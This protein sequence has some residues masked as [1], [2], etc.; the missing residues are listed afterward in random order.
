MDKIEKYINSIYRDTN[1]K[2]KGAQ[3][4]KQEMT[5][6]LK[7]TVK[8]LQDNG[9]NE[10]E[11]IRIA[12]ERFGEEFQIRNELSQVMKFQKLF[13]KNVFISSLVVL[14]VSAILLTT[15]YF[16]QLEFNKRYNVMDAQIQ[17]AENKFVNEGISGLDKYLKD[18]F[19]DENNNQLTYVAIKELPPSFDNSKNNK[20]FPG[21]IKY[22]YP[23]KIK[24]EYYSN[25]VGHDLIVNN[26]K[27]F[28][29]TGIKP[30]SNTDYSSS[31]RGM[32][33]LFF[34]ICWVLW[35]IGSIVNVNKLGELNTS[36]CIVL[37]LF[38]IVGYFIFLSVSHLNK[39]KGA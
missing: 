20:P 24:S 39:E 11:S 29:E 19:I 4:L 27:Y 34:T 28:I 2:S 13:A 21:E 5:L 17:L 35:I 10:E 32:A 8:E 16:V 6:H 38:G 30:A 36:W 3:D 33:I 1:D 14:F 22:V 26:A 7:E 18:I 9:I 25:R 15:S 23:E 37:I 31:Y 12:I